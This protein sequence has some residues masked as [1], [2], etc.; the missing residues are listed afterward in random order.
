MSRSAVRAIAP[1]VA[2]NSIEEVRRRFG[3]ARIVKLASNE[4]PLGS[5]PLA[6]AALRSADLLHLYLD[7]A[8][9]ELRERL[10]AREGLHAENVVLGHGSNELINTIAQ[11]FL[12]PG[13]EAVIADPTFSLYRSAVSL[14]G[15]IPVEVPLLNGAHDIE[16][17][18][19]AVGPRTKAFFVCDP[20]NPTGTFLSAPVW[21]ALFERLPPDV[22]LVIDRAYA[23]YLEKPGF[24]LARAVRERGNIVVLRTM[25]KAYGL[26]SLRFGYAYGDRESI[27]WLQRVRLPFNVS[28]PAAIGAAAALDDIAFLEKSVALNASER[29]RVTAELERRGHHCYPSGANFYAVTVPIAA[30]AAYEALLERGIIVRSGDALRMPGRLRVTVGTPEENDA[31]LAALAAVTSGTGE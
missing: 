1:Y 14:V 11:S 12:D 18:L 27:G 23:E 25:S 29:S 13:D 6:L 4:N 17:M 2:G 5:S 31:F 24:D 30:H 9:E 28:R 19:A 16:R 8:Y 3:H 21:S 10:G 26:A 7:D 20:N 15:A 22:L